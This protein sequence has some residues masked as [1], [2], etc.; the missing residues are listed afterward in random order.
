MPT[1]IFGAVGRFS[2]PKQRV[3]SATRETAEWYANSID[4]VIAM[5]QSIRAAKEEGHNDVDTQFQILHGD[6]PS[7]MYKKILNPYNSVDPKY[8]RFPAT[9]R[10][11]DLINGIVRRYVGEYQRNPH[12]FIVGV[13]NPDVVLARNAKLAEELIGLAQQQIAQRIEAAYQEFLNGG[14]Q[15]EQ[16]NPQEA[17]DIE[18]FIKEF[19]ENYI[20]D[21]SAQ[22][23]DIFG[24]LKDVTDD[25]GIYLRAYFEFV[26]FG[27]CYTYSDVVGNQI[28]KRVVSIR[29]AYPVPNDNMF[30]ED[31]DMFAECRKMT[32]QQIYDEY[33]HYMTK[34]QLRY[35]DEFYAKDTLGATNDR[36]LLTW[37]QFQK[38]GGD[39]CSKFSPEERNLFTPDYIMARDMNTGLYDVWHVVW[40][41]EVKEGV[42]TYQENGF[43]QTRVVQEDYQLN[44]EAGDITIDW[45]WRPQ[46]FEGVRIGSRY[47]SLYPYKARAIAYERNGKLPYNGLMELMPGLGRFSILKTVLPYQI[48]GNIVAYH[49]EMAIAKNKLNVLLIAKSLLGKKPEDTIYRMAADGV[50]YIDDE[51]DAGMLR[52]QQVRMLNSQT[53]DYITQLTTLIEANK[54]EAQ[55]QVDMT[56]QRYGEIGNSAGATTT[57][58]AILRGSMGSTIIELVFDMMRERDYAR[59]LDYSKLAWIDGL[60]TSY[61]D[62]DK[63]LKY[64]SLNVENHIYADYVVKCKISTKEMEKLQMYKDFAFS[65]AQNGDMQM[66]AIAID[67]ENAASIRKKILEFQKLKEEHEIQ[68]QQLEAQNAQMLQQF[69]LDKI[70]AKGEQDRETLQLEKYLDGE[71]EMIKANANIMSFDNGLSEQTKAQAEERMNQANINLEQQKLQVEHEKIAADRE[72]KRQDTAAKIYDS[73]IKLQVAKQNKNKYDSKPKSSSKK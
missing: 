38:F 7:D 67:G 60:D 64:F 6:I 12:N 27:E 42:L 32:A 36:G 30:V 66:A 29:D 24:V 44:T 59:D 56:P 58:E 47:N 46:V 16:F 33:S 51:E 48:F 40:R 57:Q 34:E 45:Y 70:A 14:G 21:I 69:E 26:T 73:N 65:A 28:V 35:L 54:Q 5:G 50:L 71:I 23:Q 61:R 19:N 1:N 31:Y 25:V 37:H 8:T 49:R 15:P 41:G 39:I 22:A 11:Y 20:D 62:E 2:F 18:A 53:N 10:N 9:M 63:N 68:M 52:A 72:A 55:L 17:I 43:V 4:W 13:N 3:S